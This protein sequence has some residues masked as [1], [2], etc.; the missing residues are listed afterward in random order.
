MLDKNGFRRPQYAELVASMEAEARARFGQDVNTRPLTPLGIIIRLFAWFLSLLWQDAEKVYYG[1]SLK[2]AEGIQLDRL[3]PRVG[4]TRLQAD[5]STGYVTLYGTA[6]HMEPAGFLVESKSGQLYETTEDAYLNAEGLDIVAIRALD[7]GSAGNVGAGSITIISEP[8]EDITGVTNAQPTTGG[9]EKET[10]AEFKA[11]FPQTVAGGGS[12]SVP[13]IQSALMRVPGVRAATVLENYTN[14]E[15]EGMPPKSVGAFVLGGDRQD[16]AEAVFRYKAAGIEPAGTE[17]VTV[18]DLA[19]NE[20]L[21]RFSYADEIPISARIRI[22]TN[23]EF[24]ADGAERV[25]SALVRY[26]GG[27]ESDGSLWHG[28]NMGDDVVYARILAAVMAVPGVTD[29][30]IELAAGGQDYTAG[31]IEIGPREVAQ[32]DAARIEVVTGA[33]S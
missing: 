12:A 10:D 13:A 15:R 31:N 20:H 24:P 26:V 32:A 25:R 30:V 11:R 14:E 19:G 28:L 22:T 5:Y 33:E 21:V 6:G 17:E 9:R 16:I 3:G 27:I 23:A 18:T 8:S 7:P 29:A 1:D 2:D 4:I